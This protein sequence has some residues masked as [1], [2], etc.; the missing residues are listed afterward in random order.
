MVHTRQIQG[1]TAAFGNAGALY[2]RAM[3]WWDHQTL[4]IWSQPIGAAISGPLQGTRLELLPVQIIAWESWR[5]SYPHTLVLANDLDRQRS[6]QRFREGFVIGIELGN[7]AKAFDFQAVARRGIVN[8]FVGRVPVAVWAQGQ[9]YRAYLR[10][11]EER[12]LT[13]APEGDFL[14]DAE[15]GSRWDP[16]LGLALDGPLAGAALQAAPSITSYDWAWLDFYP[17]SEIFDGSGDGPDEK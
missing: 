15:T 13:F 10:G 2:K 1:E 16:R 14:L 12:V 7:Q 9:E 8:D 5:E 6:R 4:S 3:T 11:V 17:N